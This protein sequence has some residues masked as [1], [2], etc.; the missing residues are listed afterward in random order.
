MARSNFDGVDY[1]LDLL[2]DLI[3]ANM[4]SSAS[5]LAPPSAFLNLS[6]HLEAVS[7]RVADWQSTQQSQSLKLHG[8]PFESA[9]AM[10]R[11]AYGAKNDVRIEGGAMPSEAIDVAHMLDG[12]MRARLEPGSVCKV[13]RTIYG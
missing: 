7:R 9:S 12:D 2:P 6:H 4:P 1:S 10:F 13:F 5:L 8:R 11:V 3:N